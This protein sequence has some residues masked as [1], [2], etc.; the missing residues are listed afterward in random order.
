MKLGEL[1]DITLLREDINS[2]HILRRDHPN[3]PLSILNY[4][5]SCMFEDYWS[6][7]VQVCRGLV[8]ELGEH[9]PIS[10]D[11]EIVARP[12]HKFFNLNHV[13]QPDY[14]EGNLPSIQP[15]VT[16]KVDGW[17]GILWRYNCEFPFSM[18]PNWDDKNKCHWGIASRGSFE[19]VG[20]NYASG[21]LGKLI[22]Y[23]AIDE[24]PKGYTPIFEIICRETKVVVD[25]PFEG[26]VLLALINNETGEEMPYDE[27]RNI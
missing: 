9:Q 8:I 10:E 15:T 21:R 11:C 16:E 6:P 7:A 17:F 24:F 14:W 12:F 20:A 13:S 22:K 19:S 27:L 25:Y 1:L 18:V 2:R 5:N 23:G 4:S 26:L 3:L